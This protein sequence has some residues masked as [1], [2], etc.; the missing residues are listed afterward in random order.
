[1]EDKSN[2]RDLPLYRAPRPSKR[3]PPRP[4]G[5]PKMQRFALPSL[6][7]ASVALLLT[8]P[9][10]PDSLELLGASGKQPAEPVP[11][12]QFGSWVLAAFI[13][14]PALVLA[15]VAR[16]R[17]KLYPRLFV[18]RRIITAAIVIATA[19]AVSW[20]MPLCAGASQAG[21]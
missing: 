21:Y 18:G 2:D 11:P 5:P 10:L 4:D 3:V 15:L 9:M 12:D 13:G 19:G 17:L 6:V 1:V 20:T 14:V 7:L 16:H 8:V